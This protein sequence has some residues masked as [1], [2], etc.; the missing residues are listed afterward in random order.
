MVTGVFD[1]SAKNKY[2]PDPTKPVRYGEPTY[3]EMMLGFMDYGVERPPLAKVDPR[4]LDSY[5]GRYEVGPGLAMSVTSEG[6]KLYGQVANQAKVELLPES[7][8]TFY[9]REM[10]S[11]VTFI[12]ADGTVSEAVLDM[13]GRTLRGKRVKQVASGSGGN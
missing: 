5:A 1:N 9:I 7:D 6:G 3:D 2:N 12:K 13:G 8:T 4:I 10:D 11:V